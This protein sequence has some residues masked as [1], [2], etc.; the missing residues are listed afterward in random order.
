MDAHRWRQEQ[1]FA[2]NTE[3]FRVVELEETSEELQKIITI[4]S[5]VKLCTEK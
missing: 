5:R 2:R 4:L 1:Q 3:V